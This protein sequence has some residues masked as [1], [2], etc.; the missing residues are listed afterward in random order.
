M[1][2]PMKYRSV[3]QLWINIFAEHILDLWSTS[4]L[5]VHPRVTCSFEPKQFSNLHML[6]VHLPRCFS[7]NL[8]TTVVRFVFSCT[9]RLPN[10]MFLMSLTKCCLILTIC[11]FNLYY[12]A[13][14]LVGS[15]LRLRGN[16]TEGSTILHDDCLI[17][18][19]RFVIPK[20]DPPCITD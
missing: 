8:Y 11:V 1:W 20:L 13:T 14:L 10:W 4:Q 17:Q 3:S 9:S 19:F 16:E 7:E 18:S 12:Y 15:M 2:S 6:R 5:C